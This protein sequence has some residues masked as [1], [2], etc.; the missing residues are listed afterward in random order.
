MGSH[1]EI[2]ASVAPSAVPLSFPEEGTYI[3]QKR[4]GSKRFNALMTPA[5]MEADCDDDDDFGWEGAA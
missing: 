3:G 5:L 4:L 1:K 2:H